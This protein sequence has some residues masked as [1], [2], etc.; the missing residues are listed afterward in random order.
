MIQKKFGLKRLIHFSL[1]RF[2]S[3]YDV[4][5]IKNSHLVFVKDPQSSLAFMNEVTTK[6]GDKGVVLKLA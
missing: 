1:S 4:V 6:S 2:S 5:D 3:T